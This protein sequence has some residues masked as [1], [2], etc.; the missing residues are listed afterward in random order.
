MRQDFIGAHD[1]TLSVA[2]RVH[3]PDCSASVAQ[4][5]RARIVLDWSMTDDPAMMSSTNPAQHLCLR[6]ALV[7]LS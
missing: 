2:M 5:D 1:E 6:H 3:N 7:G 4:T